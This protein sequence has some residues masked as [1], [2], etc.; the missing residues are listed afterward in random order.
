MSPR[1]CGPVSIAGHARTCSPI[2]DDQLKL[3]SEITLPGRLISVPKSP[4]LDISADGKFA[5][6]YN[7]QP[8]T[9]VAVVD[10]VARK[11]A[12]VVEI[13]GC[14]MVYPWGPSGFASLCA[15]GSLAY[16]TKQ[17]NKY[18]VKHTAQFFDG[19]NDPSLRGK[20]GRSAHRPRVLHL[21]HRHGVSRAARR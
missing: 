9:S 19:E 20:P 14:G 13:P 17:G 10:L 18:T 8:A 16:A 6:V 5:Y 12:S 7:M 3:V 15:D 4:T 11:T 2:Y 21:L 1:R